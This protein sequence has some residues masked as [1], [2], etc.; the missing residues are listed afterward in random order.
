MPLLWTAV[1]LVTA[2]L[3]AQPHEPRADPNAAESVLEYRNGAR[4]KLALEVPFVGRRGTDDVWALQLV[5]QIELLNRGDA[6]FRWLPNESWRGR[7]SLELWTRLDTGTAQRWDGVLAVDHESNHDSSRTGSRVG[8]LSLND[9]AVG[10]VHR[11]RLGGAAF[12]SR[13]T[14][15]LY[16]LS[17]SELEP[18]CESTSG[19][20]SFG[21]RAEL[22][23]DLAGY[24]PEPGWH[25]Y[26][27]LAAS[28][29]VPNGRLVAER[30][31]SLRVGVWTEAET[32]FWRLFLSASAGS[33]V[34]MDRARDNTGFGLGMSYSLR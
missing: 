24:E 22:S 8:F 23:L 4:G 27:V 10:L 21:A 29:V 9:V 33:D 20:I 6:D 14:A 1:T 32:G 17:C 16:F 12:S 26:T 5:P 18:V 11:R 34:G 28:G 7:A 31:A 30:R 13:T 15:E 3:S 25:G 2:P 19:S